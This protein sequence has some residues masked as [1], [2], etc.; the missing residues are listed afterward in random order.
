MLNFHCAFVEHPVG[1]PKSESLHCHSGVSSN[2]YQ[3]LLANG[4]AGKHEG[5][6]HD[7][8]GGGERAGQYQN[9]N[10]ES[11]WTLGF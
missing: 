10:H 3:R 6:R 1:G 4:V 8:E 11:I 7:N 5:D 9:N 2:D